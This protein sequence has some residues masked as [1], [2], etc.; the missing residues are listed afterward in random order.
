M[1]QVINVSSFRGETVLFENINFSL[2][3]GDIAQIDGRNGAGKTSLLRL[4][5]GLS[6]SESGQILWCQQPIA[7]QRALWHQQMIYLAHQPGI[8]SSLTASENLRFFHPHASLSVLH[9]ALEQVGLVGYEDLLV[10]NFSAGQQQRVGLARLWLTEAKIWILDEPFTALDK[11]GI[12]IL[13]NKIMHFAEQGGIVMLTTHQDL[14]IDGQRI[15][16][17]RLSSTEQVE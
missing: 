4:V 15:K 3:A 10:G 12:A 6:K 2:F 9:A 16:L 5:T 11:A 1:L 17:L 13:V 7:Q 8:K 14:P